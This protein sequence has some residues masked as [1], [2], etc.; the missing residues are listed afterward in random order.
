MSQA[1]FLRDHNYLH[2]LIRL[3]NRGVNC[4]ITCSMLVLFQ[5]VPT[6]SKLSLPVSSLFVPGCYKLLQ[7]CL[8]STCYKLVLFQDVPSLSCFKRFQPVPNLS[9][10]KL[11][12]LVTSCYK[13]ILFQ[14][15]LTCSKLVS[16]Q[17]VSS[18][19]NLFQADPSLS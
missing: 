18:C 4:I 2:L 12:Q 3:V 13:L 19:S 7:A 15:V 6:C 17:A 5:A 16:F 9:C 1:L 14:A 10:Y 11:F 8:I